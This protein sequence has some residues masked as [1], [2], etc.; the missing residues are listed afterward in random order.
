M[1]EVLPLPEKNPQSMSIWKMIA[2]GA[3]NVWARARELLATDP[4]ADALLA[5][6]IVQRFAQE[7]EGLMDHNRDVVKL[8]PYATRLEHL[9]VDSA[10]YKYD[11]F[12][13]VMK[14][15][16]KELWSLSEKKRGR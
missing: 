5:T 7:Y 16:E 1:L 11:I 15:Y 14:E 8:D 12:G 3:Q 6:D 13:L 10:G 4:Q 9:Q 2:H